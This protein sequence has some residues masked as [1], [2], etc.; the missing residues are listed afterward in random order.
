MRKTPTIKR[1][2]ES[3]SPTFL[4]P[5]S[6]PPTHVHNNRTRHRGNQCCKRP[7]SPLC[8]AAQTQRKSSCKSPAKGNFFPGPRLSSCANCMFTGTSET[9]SLQDVAALAALPG[10]MPPNV[11]ACQMCARN[12][13]SSNR[14]A[15]VYIIS[16]MLKKEILPELLM[17]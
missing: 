1:I 15:N 10:M 3:D 12:Y 13:F 9:F 7:C 5:S 2:I 17:L 11:L 8:F 4:P 14:D 6:S 16:E